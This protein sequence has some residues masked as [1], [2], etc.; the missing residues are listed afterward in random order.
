MDGPA[1]LTPRV[2]AVLGYSVRGHRELHPVCAARVAAAAALAREDDVVVFS[3]W[4]RTAGAESEAALMARA[5][6]GAGARTILDDGARH[7]AENAARVSRIARELGVAE[8]LVVTSRW[9]ATRAGFAFRA[10]LRDRD[11]RVELAWGDEPRN[12]PAVAREAAVW[13]VFGL[14]LARAR[15]E[16]E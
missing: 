2:V 3:G 16:V 10:L 12:V 8:I 6:T 1:P 9:H 11:V 4:A 15:R 5:W 14:Q 13:P 7:T